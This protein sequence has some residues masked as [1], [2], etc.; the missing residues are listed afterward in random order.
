MY[1][2]VNVLGVWLVKCVAVYD[3]KIQ[4][5]ENMKNFPYPIM[6]INAKTGTFIYEGADYL[7]GREYKRV[8]EFE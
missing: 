3:S 5:E 2:I 6:D 8:A 4:A 7:V 1:A